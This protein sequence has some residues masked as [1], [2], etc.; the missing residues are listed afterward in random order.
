M[1]LRECIEKH[2]HRVY[3]AWQQWLDDEANRPNRS[4]HYLMQIALEIR[5]FLYSFS[6]GKKK[7]LTLDK[8]KISFGKK[9]TKKE[10]KKEAAK[11]SLSMWK[12]VLGIK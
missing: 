6:K 9:E 11:K 3:L 4:D 1:P 5:Q 7:S 12:R 10:T 8:F 2:S